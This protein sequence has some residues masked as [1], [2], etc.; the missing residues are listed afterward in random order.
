MIFLLLYFVYDFTW[1]ECPEGWT[2]RTDTKWC[3]KPFEDKE[4]SWNQAQSQC[5]KYGADLVSYNNKG[6]MEWVY[7]ILNWNQNSGSWRYYWNGLND[8][9][10]RGNLEWVSTHSNS[11]FDYTFNNF[12]VDA[13][14]HDASRRCTFSLF[15]NNLP[16]DYGHE[17]KW[18]KEKC[19][20]TK[21][22]FVYFIFYFEHHSKYYTHSTT[23]IVL[24]SI[25]KLH[26]FYLPVM[27]PD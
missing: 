4:V 9:D 26:Q 20:K 16:Q 8:L 2:R 17:G 7:N 18:Y 6:E 23:H 19:E 14:M 21:F 25:L 24:H 12:G 15:S 3:Y 10:V 27:K 11:Q 1:A 13:D 22:G 5:V